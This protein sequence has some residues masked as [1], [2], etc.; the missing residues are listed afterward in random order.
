MAHPHDHPDLDFDHPASAH[1]EVTEEGLTLQL[2]DWAAG[3]EPVARDI[4]MADLE[5]LHAVEVELAA[6]TSEV[7]I[8]PTLARVE[9]LMD[10]LGSP[11]T[12]Y[13]VIHVAGTNGKTSTVRMIESLL[14]AFHQ[15]VGRFSSPKLQVINDQIGIDGVPLHPADFVRIYEEIKPYVAMVDADC[16]TAGTPRLSA[17]EVLVAIAVAAF[18]DA[19]VDVAVIEV[20]MGGTWDATNVVNADVAVITPIGLDH[21]GMLGSTLAEIAG[22]KAGIVKSRWNSEDLLT[23]P[24]N[25]AIIAAQEP[26]AM[27][28]IA[29]RAIDVD[30]AIAREGSE[31]MVTDQSIAV[32]GRTLTI[33]GLGGVYPDIFLPLTGEYQAHN[34]AVALAAIEAFFGAGRERALNPDTVRAGFAQVT[35]PGRL[36]RV[37]NGPP[38]FVDATHNPHGAAALA[39][40]VSEDFDFTRLIGVVSILADKDYRGILTA[41]EPVLTEVIITENRSPRVLDAEVLAEAAREIFGE[42]RV[43]VNP[44]LAAAIEQAIDL[45]DWS[46]TESGRGVLVTGSVVTAGDARTL[47]KKAPQ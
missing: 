6:R 21:Q 38:V 47:L 23:P 27:D 43:S 13:P 4:T 33:Q 14:G 11:Q 46:E 3:D 45:A 15:R 26:E 28:V 20:G 16:D 31:F 19:P 40:A 22:Q 36:E 35:T 18:A 37:R 7:E 5:A 32:G 44:D 2:G 42:E 24:D 39:Q 25:V 9:K 34:A 8:D 12:A 41:L 29:Q 17:F 10:L 1:V 30:A